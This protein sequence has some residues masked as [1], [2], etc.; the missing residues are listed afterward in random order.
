M[1][2]VSGGRNVAEA[3]ISAENRQVFTGSENP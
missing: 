2:A 1:W 3:L